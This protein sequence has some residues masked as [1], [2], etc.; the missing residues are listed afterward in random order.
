MI[1]YDDSSLN[2]EKRGKLPL[3]EGLEDFAHQVSLAKPMINFVVDYKCV[4]YKVAK[5]DKFSD[6]ENT[7]FITGFVVYENG[8][9]LGAIGT[10]HRYRGGDKDLVYEVKSFRIDKSRG[11]VNTKQSK[12]IKVALRI[13]KKMLVAR[14]E[15]ERVTL[16]METIKSSI[17]NSY[18]S[19]WN[20]VRWTINSN[21]ESFI[22]A[23]TAY[24]A[25]LRGETFAPMPAKLHTVAD[26]KVH[27]EACALAEEMAH[28]KNLFS[29]G[30]GYCVQ[31]LANDSFIVYSLADKTI[32]KYSDFYDLP[33]N[34]QGK[35]A[36][37]K[38]L[39]VGEG[40]PTVG[41]KI[42]GEF[43]YVVA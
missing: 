6:S 24:K 19:A 22:Y 7:E 26:F 27:D 33:E 1:K 28:I 16:L 29:A 35:Y 13:A 11:N 17:T 8:E 32:K 31:V 41:I 40:V 2:V 39:K 42:N 20:A 12:D 18:N 25:R 38:V 10:E 4:A 15:D 43:A 34:I 23:M 9:E 14:A 3:Y 36:M 37:F 21:D 5:K 30:R